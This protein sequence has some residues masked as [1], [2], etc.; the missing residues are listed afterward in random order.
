MEIKAG[1][2]QALSPIPTAL[3][4]GEK[5]RGWAWEGEICLLHCAKSQE[6]ILGPLFHQ[7]SCSQPLTLPCPIP[8]GASTGLT[9]TGITP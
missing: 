3:L 1:L 6:Q 9:A 2:T 4:I 8:A 5:R 7:P